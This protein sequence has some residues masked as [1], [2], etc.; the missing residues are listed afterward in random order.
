MTY[1]TPAPRPEPEPKTGVEVGDELYIH[2]K[3]QPCTGRVKAHGRHGVTMD[4]A[5]EHAQ[6]RWDKVLG[7][8]K[9][10][11]QRYSVIDQGED[12]MLVQ[13]G[14]G[15]RRFVATPNESK[16]DPMVAKSHGHTRP[17]MLFTKATPST[18]APPGPGLQKKQITDKNGV[19][20]TKWVSTDRGG[21]PAQRGQHVGFENGAHR[22]HGEVTASGQHGVTV[23][24]D[25]GGEHR[26]HHEKVT[27]HWSGEGKPDA[28]PHEGEGKPADGTPAVTKP[29]GALFAPADV[30]HLPE[31][32][33]QPAKTWD[34]LVEK[35]TEGLVH[36]KE[37]IGK[38][39]QAMGLKTGIKPDDITPEQWDND[40]GYAFVAPLKGAKRAKEKCEAD[41]GGD[42]SQ[43]R[44]IVRGTISV[45][46]MGHVKQAL[47]HMK[48]SGLEIAQKPKNRFE[49]PTPEGYRDLMTFV[50]LP[51]GM[52]AELQVHVKSMTQAKEKG[53]KDY[54][55]TRTLQGKHNEPEPTDK[56]PEEDHTKF[57]EAVK[58]QKDIYNAA[59]SR[60]NG[61]DQKPLIKSDQVATLSLLFRRV[62]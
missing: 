33:N 13:D 25:A 36:F 58:R 40:D 62:L 19:Q 43:L 34:E 23:K 16:E 10:A 41:Y 5:G 21:P 2:H 29:T 55:I 8:K 38:V 30:E 15:R 18:G 17:V 28:S 37:M 6:V 26:V 51:N 7:H 52:V 44:D 57:Y 61:S 24:D 3:G 32:V 59:W 42:W 50:R 9:R 54:E 56:W 1:K 60:A 27:H 14:T 49:K 20:T 39:S 47:E 31:K 4:V 35:G 46:T 12:G 11:L 22:G 53:H 48:A 45:P